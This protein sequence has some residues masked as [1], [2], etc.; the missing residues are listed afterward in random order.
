M[1]CDKNVFKKSIFVVKKN[2]NLILASKLKIKLNIENP[3]TACGCE[4]HED[5]IFD[6]R[7]SQMFAEYRAS[8]VASV[9][10]YSLQTKY[11]RIEDEFITFQIFRPFAKM[12]ELLITKNNCLH[13]RALAFVSPTDLNTKRQFPLTFHFI[14]LKYFRF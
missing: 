11:T 14:N 12:F 3:V 1:V 13:S 7:E 8:T 4:T 6:Y 9:F 10:Q 5:R 2:N